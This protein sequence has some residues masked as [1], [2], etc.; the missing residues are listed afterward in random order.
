MD[1]SWTIK[2]AL[3]NLSSVKHPS[4][5]RP[6]REKE[7]LCL[8]RRNGA[9]RDVV[10][11]LLQNPTDEDLNG[12]GQKFAS[13]E[14]PPTSHLQRVYPLSLLALWLPFPGE[15]GQVGYHDEDDMTPLPP[16]LL[17]RRTREAN[18][19]IS[20]LP[21]PP[22]ERRTFGAFTSRQSVSQRTPRPSLPG[23]A[24]RDG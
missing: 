5:R 14:Y 1:S 13:L 22:P 15:N 21:P 24:V 4:W 6:R 2:I 7:S 3:N 8:R 11:G 17:P 18:L 9:F 20:R 16:S 23:A 10:R 12:L 19:P